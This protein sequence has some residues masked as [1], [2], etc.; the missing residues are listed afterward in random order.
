MM[1]RLRQDEGGWALAIAMIV[2]LLMLSFGL[3]TAA[4]VDTQTNESKRERNRESSFN[5]TE[6]ALQEQGYVLGFNW[7][8][9]VTA[10]YPGTCTQSVTT[11][12]KCPVPA[13]LTGGNFSGVDFNAGSTWRTVVR[14]NPNK[15]D[16]YDSSALTAT[17]KDANGAA[18]AS[19]VDAAGN[20]YCGWDANGD[21]KLW[22]WATGTAKGRTR[23]MVALLKRERLLEA[24]P[25]AA[26]RADHFDVTNNGN[27]EI[28]DASAGQVV[29]R[30]NIPNNPQ[31]NNPCTGWDPAKGQVVGSIVQEPAQ[32]QATMDSGQLA[33]FRSAAQS[34]GT[35]YTSCPG[36]LAGSIVYI[37]LPSATDCKYQTNNTYN[38][39]TAPGFLI[40]PQGTL[41]V[42]G[43]V[44]Y[45]GVI[46]LGNGQ[47]ST[48]TVADIGG[49]GGIIG[50]V[51]VDWGGGLDVGSNGNSGVNNANIRFSPT[52]FNALSTFGTAGLVQNTWR[53]LP[54]GG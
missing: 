38:T 52:A 54:P 20:S 39:A 16:F 34:N 44:T 31:P 19:Q 45:Y 7:P 6:G 53:E 22:V 50:G 25:R 29:V 15:S 49:N 13:N 4:I 35:Y 5:L 2:L 23:L 47:H 17:C 18:V 42:R 36:S 43:G 40:M 3:A 14:D 28:I 48:G 37:D 26:V 24:L 21:R 9:T 33:R 30:C 10:A 8:A 12:G 51:I 41:T 27:K 32:T 11:A 1:R 46:Y